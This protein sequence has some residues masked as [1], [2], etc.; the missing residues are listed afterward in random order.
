MKNDRQPP[1]GGNLKISP[2]IFEI[3]LMYINCG[4]YHGYDMD[5]PDRIPS[6]ATAK[7]WHDDAPYQQSVIR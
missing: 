4:D 2:L 1:T 7:A 6:G 5:A 3:D